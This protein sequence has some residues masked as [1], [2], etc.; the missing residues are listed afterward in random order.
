MS[1]KPDM[2][3]GALVERDVAAV[4]AAAREGLQRESYFVADEWQDAVMFGL[5]RREW[6]ARR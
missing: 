3:S 6:Q 2:T 4:G 5:L 1:T